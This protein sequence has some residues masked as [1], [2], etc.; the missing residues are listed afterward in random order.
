MP[1]TKNFKPDTM[2]NPLV[3][4]PG[5]PQ[6]MSTITAFKIDILIALLYS[7]W[8]IFLCLEFPVG[9]LYQ[10]FNGTQL[11]NKATL[12]IE[13]IHIKKSCKIFITFKAFI[14][15]YPGNTFHP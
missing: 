2:V 13:K 6:R 10:M 15:F 1:F 3:V 8:G 5:F 11:L 14:M 7:M 12:K 9:N 4:S